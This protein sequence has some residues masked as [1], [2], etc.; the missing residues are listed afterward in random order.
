MTV[1]RLQSVLVVALAVAGAWDTV[2]AQDQPVLTRGSTRVRSRVFN[3]FAIG[4][5]RLT[6][7]PF[8][9]I[10]LTN[11]S[12]FASPAI[13]PT[14]SSAPS[15]SATTSTPAASTGNSAGGSLDGGFATGAA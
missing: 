5:S 1:F 6:I 2:Q 10:T 8:G 12:P 9:T 15:S 4:E 11:T 13:A 7:D 3:P 14:S